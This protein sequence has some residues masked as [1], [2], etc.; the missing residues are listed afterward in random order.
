MIRVYADGVLAYDSRLEEY[1]LQGLKITRGINKGGAAEIT[2]PAHHPAYGLFRGF[3]TIVEIYRDKSLLFRGRALYP[4]DDYYNNRTVTCEGE[5]CFF[6]D[7]IHRRYKYQGTP[8]EIFTAVVGVYNDQVDDFKK[9]DVGYVGV[10]DPNDYIRLES[11]SAE[12]VMAVLNKLVERCGGELT[13]TGGGNSRA[14]I[15]WVLQVGGSSDQTIEMGENLLNFS[16]TEA[17]TQLA[18]VLVPYGAKKTSA[19]EIRWDITTV[20]DGKD[21][22]EDAE[23][24]ARFGRIVTT[25][26]WDDVTKPENLLKKAREYLDERKQVVNSLKLTA[27]DLSYVDKSI[28]SFQLGATIRVRS[29]V[30][31]IDEKFRLVEIAEDLVRPEQSTITLGKERRSLTG[32]DAANAS[33]TKN[34]VNRLETTMGSTTGSGSVSATVTDGVLYVNSSKGASIK[35]DVLYLT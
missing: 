1:D 18:T 25:A 33:K 10:T 19:S 9:F 34:E 29:K 28:E 13:F 31:G 5:L 21:Y 22:I 32:M 30:H 24:V 23:A 15:H 3:K 27:L 6:Q 20:N 26:T 35:D 11:E 17:N 7:A 4:T 8:A 12:P 2:M 14:M 16:R